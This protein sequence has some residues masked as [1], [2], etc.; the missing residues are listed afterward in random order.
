MEPIVTLRGVRRVQ[1]KVQGGKEELEEEGDEVRK[2]KDHMRAIRMRW[3][4]RHALMKL[5]SS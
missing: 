4:R 5:R 1:D 2:D 3:N